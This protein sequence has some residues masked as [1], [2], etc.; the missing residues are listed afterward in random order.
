VEAL[1]LG[2]P[3]VAAASDVHREI[4]AEGG[5][6]ADAAASDDGGERGEEL[7][8]ALRAA[9]GSTAAAE[10]LGVLAGDRGRAFSWAGAAERVWQLHADL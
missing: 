3:I 8:E 10:R 6:L 2:V 1:R 4:V 9:L 7:G 5:L